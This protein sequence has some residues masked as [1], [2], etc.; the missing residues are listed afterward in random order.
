MIEE[1][2][3]ACSVRDSSSANKNFVHMPRLVDKAKLN[4]CGKGDAIK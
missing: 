3:L 4:L 1:S 2:C